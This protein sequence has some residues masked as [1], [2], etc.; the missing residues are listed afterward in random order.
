MSADEVTTL[1]LCGDVMLGRGVDQVLA[2]PGDPTL[3][4][5][6]IH[7]ARQYVELAEQTSGPIPRPVAD[8]WPWGE[9]L[10]EIT[11]SRPAVLVVNLETAVT[12]GADFAVGKAIHYRMTPENLSCLQAVEP[13]VVVLA[14]N[15]VLD[16]GRS[17]LVD[18]LHALSEAGLTTAGAGCDLD[19]ATAPALVT[20]AGHRP[21]AVLGYGDP[22]SGI[23]VH[24][25]ARDDRPGVALL[26]D[27]SDRTAATVAARVEAVKE[28]GW[29]V[30]VSVHWGS[31]WGYGVP[32]DQVRFAHRVVEAG[33]DVVHGHS[34]H[35]P[36]PVEVYAG[37]AILY[38]CGDFIDD[39]EG[40]RGHEEYRNDLRLLYRLTLDRSGALLAAEL[41]PFRSRRLRLE[42][43]P[44]DD[45]RWL[46]ALLDQV[47]HGRGVRARDHEGTIELS[48]S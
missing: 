24:W 44:A 28:A 29:I 32:A 46:S 8:D 13:D 18:S 2:H 40:I 39:Y 26:P 23:R 21:V 43:P 33:A 25:A 27:L 19:S 36:R 34:S 30:V 37:R 10:E 9:A 16:F 20:G 4:E 41:V 47:S 42:R 31:N 12:R 7:D 35:H 1:L 15:H 38:G 45:V 3:R 14:N 11:R 17:G 22:S 6:F 48:W 5:D